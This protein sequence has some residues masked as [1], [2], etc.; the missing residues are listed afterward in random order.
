MSTHT[1]AVTVVRFS[2]NG[3]YLASGSD[4][5]VVLIWE[6]D[7]M[8]VPRQEFGSQGEADSEVWVA[9]KR[10]VGHDNDVQDLAWA[11]D[12]SLLVTVGLD[13]SII[14]WSGSTFERL[15]RFDAHESHVKGITFDPARK[16]FATSSDDRTVRIIRYHKPSPN[17]ITFSIESTIS[18]PF[19]GSPISTYFRRL[20]WSPDGNH[21]AA[22]NATNGPVPTI[23][24][25]NRGT[26]DSDISLI[27]HEAPVEVASFCPR[28]FLMQKPA[29]GDNLESANPVTVVATAGQ[30]K[31]LAIWNTSNPRPL[32]VARNVAEKAITDIV[33]SPDGTKMY[34]SSLDGTILIASFEDG[35]L[36][37]PLDLE[38]AQKQLTR[39]GGNKDEMQIPES[40]EQLVLEE[41]INDQEKINNVKRMDELMGGTGVDTGDAIGVVNGTENGKMDK[42]DVDSAVTANG[43]STPGNASVELSNSASQT[44]AAT[45]ATAPANETATTATT[46]A[47][48][49]TTS[50]T[51]TTTT[52]GS[53]NSAATTSTSTIG[54]AASSGTPS[55]PKKITQR[56]TITKDG[57][58]RVAPQL[59]TTSSIE[60]R[61]P[62]APLVNAAGA[63]A[64]T[65]LSSEPH[66]QAMEMSKP[67]YNLPKGGVQSL[68]IGTKRK[69][70]DTDGVN[71][72]EAVGSGT[73]N[74]SSTQQKKQKP[75]EIPEFIR[76]AVVS[77]ATTV[78]QVRL[79][80]PKVQTFFSHGKGASAVN[81]GRSV[82]EIRNGTGNEQEPTKVSVSKRGQIVFVDFLPRYG[83]L[84]AGDGSVFWAVAT[85]DGVIHVYTAA[86][87]RLL[88]SIVL[89]SSI[90]FLESQG[91]YLLAITSIG[92][93]HIWDMK[94]QVA[95][96]KPAV[97]LAPILDTSLKYVENGL[98]R[99]PNVTQCGVTNKGHAIITLSNGQGYTYNEPMGSWQRISDSWYAF[100][101]QYWDSNGMPGVDVFGVSSKRDDGS[102]SVAGS[103]ANRRGYSGGL[104]AL[105]ERRTNEEVVVKSGSRGRYLQRLAKNRML[106]EGYEGFEA[107]VSLAHLETRISAAIVLDSGDE[108]RKFLITYA[109][110]VGEEGMKDRLEELCKDLLGPEGD[111]ASADTDGSVAAATDGQL[112][113]SSN[114][115]T[116]GPVP[117]WKPTLCD[118]QKK[119]LLKEV[120]FAAGKIREVQHVLLPYAR[121][122]GLTLTT[123]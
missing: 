122:L 10:L 118:I 13:S 40:V 29:P 99:A 23:A 27:G 2:P 82:L 55:T 53:A 5:R 1:G 35:E 54:A 78:S 72:D 37:W 66:L 109:R 86:G 56:I 38:E 36:G 84:A 12:S 75:E 7:E 117:V 121:A 65:N 123:D 103:R 33:W 120:I 57:K 16:Y 119:D 108:L 4:D 100:G 50:S 79:A 113:I 14:I 61:M 25:I 39:Y 114:D 44:T 49:T 91:P 98:S 69:Q 76:P 77:P 112:S 63:A 102:V 74:G 106:Q 9:R 30:D 22:S 111:I 81:G 15:K 48:N 3:R 87:R 64:G 95:V 59:L 41:K 105:A 80:V 11:P 32:L 24:I 67:S 83:H 115:R 17:E 45:A 34:A 43:A 97:S 6:R 42:M 8:R 116:S 93:V 73:V 68:V 62:Q 52:T 31:T 26:W 71:G 19:I 60:P 94:R 18:A 96:L 46:T 47:A 51:P 107:A 28:V 89:G 21:I 58:K 20:S 70:E 92:M 110:R 90:S 104:I 88:P 101:S 85:E